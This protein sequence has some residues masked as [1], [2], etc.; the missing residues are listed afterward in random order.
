MRCFDVTGLR[1]S[2]C[3][4]WIRL[5]E[6]KVLRVFF[7]P[8]SVR[9]QSAARERPS[10]RWRFRMVEPTG[11]Y[12]IM[13]RSHKFLS[14]C[15]VA[16]A[17]LI[18][19]ATAA[20]ADG[21]EYEGKAMAA[22]EEGRKFTYSFSLTGTSDYVFRGVS[23][24]D[25]DPTIQGAFDI[26]YGIFYAGV[27]GSGV[28]FDQDLTGLDD[29]IEVDYYAGIK[30]TWHGA[31]F[32]FGVIYYWYPGTLSDLFEL[33]AGVSG[34]VFDKLSVG[35]TV[36]YN[37]DYNAEYLVYEGS[38]G[39]EFHAIRDF[40]PTI[41]GVIGRYDDQLGGVDYTYWNAGLGIAV[42]NI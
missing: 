16:G 21:Y 34:T 3:S 31:E 5:V 15:G 26:G 6:S 30:P 2:Y 39:Y 27:W 42:G 10:S 41:G 24:T 4:L 8:R 9:V 28:D 14:I 36:Y 23:Q 17:A 29:T 38:L 1:K 33:K 32:D 13:A 18:A 40:T 22:P 7:I 19:C 12:S 37:P 25:N 35:A 20:V 11:V